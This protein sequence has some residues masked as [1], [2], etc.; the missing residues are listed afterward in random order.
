MQKDSEA[1]CRIIVANAYTVFEAFAVLDS[2]LLE[3]R[4]GE[5][6]SA[7]RQDTEETEHMAGSSRTSSFNSPR[8]VILDS[9]GAIV[10]PVLGGLGQNHGHALLSCIGMLLKQVALSSNCAVLV[11]NHT[12]STG[13]VSFSGKIRNQGDL[14]VRADEENVMLNEGRKPALGES[15]NHQTHVRAQLCTPRYEGQAYQAIMMR[16]SLQKSGHRVQYWLGK[17]GLLSCPERSTEIEK[18]DSVDEHVPV[19]D[20]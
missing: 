3:C 11:T 12:V 2:L 1:L 15:W 16:N 6:A 20:G 10:S 9:I 13:N 19:P 5:I 17:N 18:L 7:E 14:N 8:L 4:D